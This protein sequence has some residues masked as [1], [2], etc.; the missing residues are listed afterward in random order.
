MEVVGRSDNHEAR[1]NAETKA[2]L[3]KVKKGDKV[4]FENI[5]AVGDDGVPHDLG[6]VVAE[7]F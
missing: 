1:F 2:L 4:Y 6:T 3:Q 5:R 7:I